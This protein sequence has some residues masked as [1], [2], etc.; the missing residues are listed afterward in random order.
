MRIIKKRTRI[1]GSLWLVGV[2]WDG[3]MAR[4]AFL[5]LKVDTGEVTVERVGERSRAVHDVTVTGVTGLKGRR[6]GRQGDPK[7]ARSL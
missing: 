6:F 3:F 1:K 7:L 2:R 4:V 5:L